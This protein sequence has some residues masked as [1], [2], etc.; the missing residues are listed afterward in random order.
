M[1]PDRC[2]A[3]FRRHV[4]RLVGHGVDGAMIYGLRW[5]LDVGDD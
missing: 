5:L 2:C 3:A 4:P 1:T